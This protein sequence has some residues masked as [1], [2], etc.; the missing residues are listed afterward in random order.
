MARQTP[1]EGHGLESCVGLLKP[2][3]DSNPDMSD[4]TVLSFSPICVY[5][6]QTSHPDSHLCGHPSTVPA[7][8]VVFC[9]E[10]IFALE[11]KHPYQEP[12]A[13]GFLSFT[14]FTSHL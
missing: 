6:P 4:K 1:A 5:L 11:R 7:R 10:D 9:W 13:R 2:T 14:A 8:S 12:E 3:L